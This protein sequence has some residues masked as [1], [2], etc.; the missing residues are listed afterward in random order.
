M[1][2]PN[3]GIC[4]ACLGQSCNVVIQ[5]WSKLRAHMNE[6]DKID[7][8]SKEDWKHR[9]TESRIKAMSMGPGNLENS[10]SI[11]VA[12]MKQT[13]DEED[14]ESSTK[15]RS[16]SKPNVRIVCFGCLADNCEMVCASW[17]EIMQHMKYCKSIS[18][19]QILHKC[20]A[21]SRFKAFGTIVNQHQSKRK[22]LHTKDMLKATPKEE[23][24]MPQLGGETSWSSLSIDDVS[25]NPK[26]VTLELSTNSSA[27]HNTHDA[28]NSL[29][30]TMSIGCTL[31][32]EGNTAN[33]LISSKEAE[34]VVARDHFDQNV[35][36]KNHFA[37]LAESC[38]VVCRKWTKICNHMLFCKMI[39]KCTPPIWKGQGKRKE[40]CLKAKSF[41]IKEG[42]TNKP[43]T[44]IVAEKI[45]P[46]MSSYS[47]LSKSLID[48]EKHRFA[49]LGPSCGQVY[50][51]W[52]K[53]LDHMNICKLGRVIGRKRMVSSHNLA[54]KIDLQLQRPTKKVKTST[55]INIDESVTA[56]TKVPKFNGLSLFFEEDE[57]ASGV[58]IKVKGSENRVKSEFTDTAED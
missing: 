3:K 20:R 24:G 13:K 33:S 51:G 53:A 57:S 34:D 27:L 49:C 16:C 7:V 26:Q 46:K 9:M 29:S 6:C 2:T 35:I 17:W 31:A 56:I 1:K 44:P 19:F 28:S 37:C 47:K 22:A 50:V 10:S 8:S 39:E 5:Q 58:D 23:G 15:D 40:S 48:R 38:F 30:R 11:Q 41:L 4:Y 32:S 54:S 14:E 21:E 25:P 45:N 12:P 55:D 52:E 36:R 42:T 18:D 43:E